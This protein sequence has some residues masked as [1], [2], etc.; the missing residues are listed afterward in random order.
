MKKLC[1]FVLTLALTAGLFGCASGQGEIK[2]IKAE[3]VYYAYEALAEKLGLQVDIS[4]PPTD[5]DLPYFATVTA[6]DMEGNM[7]VFHFCSSAAEAESYAEERQWNGV[8]WFLT[9]VMGK[10][11]WLTTTTYGSI[12]IEYDSYKLYEPFAQMIR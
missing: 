7:I 1:C 3:E 6:R 8:L 11:S 12:E 9:L 4:N 2:Q 10:S 5:S